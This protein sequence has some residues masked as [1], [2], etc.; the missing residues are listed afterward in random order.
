[1]TYISRGFRC[2]Q[3]ALRDV[4]GERDTLDR[5]DGLE[6]QGADDTEDDEGREDPHRVELALRDHDHVAEAGGAADELAGDGPI[7]GPFS[8]D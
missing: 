3:V 7:L 1:M 6:Q 4:P 8:L 2:P 5:F